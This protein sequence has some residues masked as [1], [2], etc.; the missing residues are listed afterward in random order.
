[1]QGSPLEPTSKVAVIVT[2]VRKRK[3]L[4]PEIPPL[5]RFLDKL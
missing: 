1:M 3:G 5:E 2:A 4:A